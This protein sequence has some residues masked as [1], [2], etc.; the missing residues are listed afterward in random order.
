[1]GTAV[2][3][4]GEKTTASTCKNCIERLYERARYQAWHRSGLRPL[5]NE[6][7]WYRRIE[8]CACR[9]WVWPTLILNSVTRP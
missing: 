4:R 7:G 2:I 8:K 5:P 1:M 3:L 6:A 9:N